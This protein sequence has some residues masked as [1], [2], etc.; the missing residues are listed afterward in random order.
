MSTIPLAS[1]S[2]DSNP[3][4]WRGR[5]QTEPG[6][7]VNSFIV[8]VTSSRLFYDLRLTIPQRERERERE[9]STP[10]RKKEEEEEEEEE[11]VR[12]EEVECV[13]YMCV[14]VCVY[15]RVCVCVCVSS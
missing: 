4:T 7:R 1:F 11:D 2:L 8:T 14:C 10:N 15:V 13:R 9:R 6:R 12:E 5:A 3:D